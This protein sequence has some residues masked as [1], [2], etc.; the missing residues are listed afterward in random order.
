[1]PNLTGDLGIAL[2]EQTGSNRF[3]PGTIPNP[4][5][6]ATVPTNADGI[7][8]FSAEGASNGPFATLGRTWPSNMLRKAFGGSSPLTDGGDLEL[9]VGDD[10]FE[11]IY[12]L[13][14]SIEFGIILSVLNEDVDVYS[15]FRSGVVE[16][17]NYDDSA[18]GVG[19]SLGS[20]APPPPSIFL[21]P[22]T[23][24]VHVLTVDPVGPPSFDANA[25]FDFLDPSL[26]AAQRLMKISGTRAALFSFEPESPLPETLQW[27][28][29]VIPARNEKEQ[30]SGRRKTPR[31]SLQIETR[32]EGVERQF[33][34]NLMF[35]SQA[36]PF[37]VPLWYEQTELTAP[38]AI[39]DTVINVT[40]TDDLN[41][42]VGE[43]AVMWRDARFFE[44]LQVLA[45]TS[46]TITFS[47]SSTKSFL[48]GAFVMPV[49]T[50]VLLTK[51][52]QQK[53]INNLQV[54][55]FVFVVT[56][57]KLDLSDV[58]AFNSYLP[59][60]TAENPN[61]VT[62][63]LLDDP[64][65]MRGQTIAQNISRR[66]IVI[67]NKTSFPIVFTNQDVSRESSIKTFSTK[68]RTQLQNVRKLLHALNG[69]RIAFYAPTFFND[70]QILNP[71]TPADTA[72]QVVDVDY[73][74]LVQ[75]R[76][77]RD[78]ARVVLKDGTDSGPLLI[79][80]S[81]SGTPGEETIS[82][83]PDTIGLTATVDQVDRV[84]Y[85]QK[86][87]IDSDKI[88]IEHLDAAGKAL[89]SFPIKTVLENDG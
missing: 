39:N 33:L 89:I 77:S 57:N 16:W 43:V 81:S 18:A 75:E 46:T 72:I 84:E 52:G 58:S 17:T 61:P 14:R 31:S 23:G 69:R 86:I 9:G 19:V 48:A 71:I 4:P 73:S 30:R 21:Q 60:A 6:L 68:N 15:A 36:R 62:R 12:V 66:I 11:D 37:G 44:T 67:D 35:E 78:I 26:A 2:G 29:R 87:R 28:T 8:P 83:S 41:F 85:I 63:V 47:S 54:D 10:F 82:F 50:A 42:Q 3:K 20:P 88:K 22:Q 80:G 34:E 64:N 45:F 25:V 59:P 13:P 55:N 49:S 27:Q 79:T 7:T 5:T 74:T 32:T 40:N 1:M 56:D 65:I 70:L 24:S 51:V 76:R 53:F 38:V